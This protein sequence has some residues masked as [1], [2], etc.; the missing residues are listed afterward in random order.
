MTRMPMTVKTVLCVLLITGPAQADD[1]KPLF[2]GRDLSGWQPVAGAAG[3][4]KVQDGLLYC[5]GGGGWL[6]TTEEFD[7]F[8]LE[9]EFRVPEGGNSGVFLR[10]PHV[11]NPA[12][13]G[14]EIQVLDD[15]AKKYADLRPTQY[16][17]SIYDVVAASPRVTK[18]AGAWQKMKIRCDGRHVQVTLN[19]TRIVDADL[20]Q[21]ADKVETHPGLRRTGGYIGLQNHGSRLDYRNLRVRALP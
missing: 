10:A 4:W 1:F 14:M 12:Y 5:T 20:D 18:K 15:H 21:H 8:E 13:A 11:G 2:N 6:S 16:T 17:G 9:L 7:N 3:H 19:G